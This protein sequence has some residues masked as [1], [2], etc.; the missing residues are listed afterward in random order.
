[1]ESPNG[2]QGGGGDTGNEVFDPILET[3]RAPVLHVARPGAQEVRTK[4]LQLARATEE[5]QIIEKELHRLQNHVAHIQRL[6]DAKKREI[7][8]LSSCIA[9]IRRIPLEILSMIVCLHVHAN[10]Q[11]VWVL[12][13]TS[14]AWRAASLLAGDAWNSI[15][16]CP[17]HFTWDDTRPDGGE[18]PGIICSSKERLLYTL[19]RI[20]S[21]ALDIEISFQS[22]GKSPKCGY[23]YGLTGN[24]QHVLNLVRLVPS[25][26]RIRRLR[27]KDRLRKWFS[28]SNIPE[29]F[30]QSF[31]SWD[32]SNL[33]RLDTWNHT[34]IERAIREKARIHDLGIPYQM[35]TKVD[36]PRLVRHLNLWDHSGSQELSRL[37]KF[38]NL[39]SLRLN[40]SF[41]Y[42]DPPSPTISVPHLQ[43][44]T[45]E[46][47]RRLL[48][49]IM[50]F[51]LRRLDLK[52][53]VIGYSHTGDIIHLPQLKEFFYRRDAFSEAPFLQYF[54][55]P[56]LE[57]LD[58]TDEGRSPQTT[59]R[60]MELIWPP[61]LQPATYLDPTILKL[62]H[63]SINFKLLH[64]VLHS[65]TR[66]IEL[67]LL[68]M[69]VP[70]EF[71]E[72][73]CPSRP[74]AKKRDVYIP[75]LKV[76]VID[77]YQK[78]QRKSTGGEVGRID[79][80]YLDAARRFLQR[81]KDMS[82]PLHI[83]SISHC[84]VKKQ[85]VGS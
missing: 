6:F 45:L 4:T 38:T 68:R 78:K 35:L 5:C 65:F 84:D 49:P 26:V 22:K 43:D 13:Q 34:L 64:Y 11:S 60:A 83:L 61:S 15:V 40:S 46:G 82:L 2:S 58:T 77:L 1:M 16:I 27:L 44:L 73:L 42:N 75:S 79:E 23:V 71:F 24:E 50:C 70:V 55:A 39:V 56:A 20:G 10:R 62:R 12:M 47:T 85:L 7:F 29:S 57:V 72:V 28:D 36:A 66:C 18:E 54:K 41:P 9:P 67:H 53:R 59:M 74:N 19:N 3:S 37:D 80:T 31:Q 51:N 25:S 76:L 81:R 52:Q 69:R 63:V 8:E 17:P 21:K 14:R 33:E 30:S 32:L 48:W